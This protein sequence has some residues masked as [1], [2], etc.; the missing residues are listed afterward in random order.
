MTQRSLYVWSDDEGGHTVCSECLRA[1]GN[2]AACQ[3]QGNM[4]DAVCEICEYGAED[5]KDEA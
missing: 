5:E 1:F 3:I 4:Q 2:P